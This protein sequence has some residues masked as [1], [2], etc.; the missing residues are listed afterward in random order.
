MNFFKKLLNIFLIIIGVLLIAFCADLALNKTFKTSFEEL[1]EVDRQAL[2]QVGDVINLFDEEEGNEDI[3]NSNYN[4]AQ[5]GYIISR[6]YGSVKG[7]S[8]VINV[9]LTENIFAQKIEMPS[10]YDD[11]LVFRLSASAPQAI[12]LYAPSNDNI[13]INVNGEEIY[14]LKYSSTTVSHNGS[15]SFEESYVRGTFE[16]MVQTADCPTVDIEEDFSLTE[17]NVALTG[18]QYRILDDLRE[19]KDSE[20][21]KELVAEYVIVR[22]YQLKDNAEFARQQEEVELV[23]G[24]PQYV[25]YNISGELGHNQTYFNRSKSNDIDFYSA[26]YYIC[27]GQYQSDPLEYFTERGNAYV[28]A[29][30]CEIIENKNIVLDWSSL[31]DEST[32]DEFISQYYLIKAYYARACERYSKKTIEDIQ[33]EYNY[34]EI[35]NMAKALVDGVG[36]SES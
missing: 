23:Q 13:M 36:G 10:E 35:L 26:Y 31:L 28:G 32:D 16:T 9:D 22:E 2:S 11:I 25:F 5:G 12:S 21:I 20:E 1:S 15:D 3:W 29:A 33:K 30:L 17:E 4:L 18:L 14:S 24:C 27:T 7:T 19:A 6:T 34:D 8:Y